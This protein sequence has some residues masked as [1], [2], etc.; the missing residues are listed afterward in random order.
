MLAADDD[1]KV[2]ERLINQGFNFNIKRN[3]RTTF[4]T[5]IAQNTPVINQSQN[6][7]Y[8]DCNCLNYILTNIP[9]LLPT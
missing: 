4:Y 2:I 9:T 6:I 8:I 1:G 3:C 7:F 5:I